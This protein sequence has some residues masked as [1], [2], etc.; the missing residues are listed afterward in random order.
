MDKI[1]DFYFFSSKRNINCPE[2]KHFSL[3]CK[4]FKL[5]YFTCLGIIYFF[6]LCMC[7]FHLLRGN[8]KMLLSIKP[9]SFIT[10]LCQ[11]LGFSSDFFNASHRTGDTSLGAKEHSFSFL[12]SK[13]SKC[14][15]WP[16]VMF[17]ILVTASF[18]KDE[19]ETE[20]LP[21]FRQ[22]YNK[23]ELF[24]K[25]TD[26][27]KICFMVIA[28]DYTRGM[29]V[30]SQLNITSFCSNFF[31]LTGLVGKFS[32]FRK[33]HRSSSCTPTVEILLGNIPPRRRWVD[34]QKNNVIT[35]WLFCLH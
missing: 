1:K 27:I 11:L 12:S 2:K 32:I 28:D 7:G 35:F 31:S 34:L 19:W 26:I 4:M 6:A 10:S 3:N 21:C 5:T 16:W 33:K 25:C 14:S 22:I 23:K 20:L 24:H 8:W 18:Q 30:P 29:F 15:I 9:E 13:K 17:E